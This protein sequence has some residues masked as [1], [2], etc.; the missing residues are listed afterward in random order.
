MSIPRKEA[1][2][3]PRCGKETDIVI[4]ESL[5][6]E[7]NP[8]EKQ[9]LLDGTLFRFT[10]DCG[11]TAGVDSAMLYH[12]MTHHTMVYYVSEAMVEQIDDMF[13]D[14]RK[15]GAFEM[16]D[17]KF[18]IVTSQNALR[19]KA[20]IFDNDLDDRVM[21]LVKLFC[22]VHIH[23]QHPEKQINEVLFFTEEGKWLLQFIGAASMTVE[24]PIEFYEKI[25]DQYSKRLA[26]AGDDEMHI[27]FEWALHFLGYDEE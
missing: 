13:A 19:E 24:I 12:D 20:I 9:Q 21:E 11:Y 14:I 8:K 3:C 18:R 17:Y 6:A 7:L 27:N 2:T 15:N 16:R 10:C 23:K 1:V 5:N 4:W 25:Q 22:Y 26:D